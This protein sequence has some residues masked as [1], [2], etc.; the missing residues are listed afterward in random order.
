M[1]L[2]KLLCLFLC[3]MMIVP[4]LSFCTFAANDDPEMLSELFKF[5]TGP[6]TDGYSIDYRYFS[7][8][9]ENDSTK[10][11][12]V[13]WLHGMGNGGED[14][15]QLSTSNIAYW[16]SDDFQSRFKNSGGAFIMAPR[17]LEEENLYWSD[18]LIFPLRRTIDSFIEENRENIDVKRI[19]V[20]GYSMGGKMTLKLAVAYP[21]MFAA[22][23]PICP[24]WVPGDEAVA[25]LK[26][27]PMWLTSGVP[28]TVAHYFAFVMP[29]WENIVKAS[30]R[31]EDLRFSSLEIVC[32]ENGIPTISPH[33][34][35]FAVNHDMFSSK[36]GDY[37]FMTT[38]N[39]KG[40][41]VNLT[42]PD[43][44]ISWL[45]G[46]ESNFDGS[47]A[48]DSGN[49]AVK[50]EGANLSLGLIFEILKNRIEHFVSYIFNLGERLCHTYSLISKKN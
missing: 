49:D 38:V 9:K 6:E 2:K 8:V 37:P 39:G 3:L 7:P 11:P 50:D 31:P 28:D 41:Y 23:F 45:S 21:D 19:Y 20:G 35:W 42:Y 30:N 33:F 4:T 32:Y 16:A 5:G 47:A 46:Y 25:Q 29:T 14:G 22:I 13:I 27:I 18:E 24:A 15:K 44:M 17:S 34:A 40:G 36:N 43:G 10:Y 26:D 1:K 48:T 12:L